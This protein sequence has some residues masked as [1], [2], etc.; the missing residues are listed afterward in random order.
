MFCNTFYPLKADIYYAVESQN[1]FG[2]M[3]RAW[4]FNRVIRVDMN[5]STNYKDQ[6]VQPDQF[7]WVQDML[8][9]MT[10]TDIR[11]SDTGTLYSLTN[12]IVTNIRNN[13]EEVVYSESAG[14]RAGLPTLYEVSGLLPHN[15]PW[16]NMDY[17]KLVLKRSELQEFVD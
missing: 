10:P 15:D 5:M 17:Y 7:F 3:D 12:T 9:G 16:G 2:E 6:Q 11:M 4:E 13:K 1:D 8:N 14:D